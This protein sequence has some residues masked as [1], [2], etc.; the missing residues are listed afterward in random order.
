VSLLM[1]R[2]LPISDIG[3]MWSFEYG[4]PTGPFWVVTFVQKLDG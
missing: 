3:Q 1:G 2:G 4:R